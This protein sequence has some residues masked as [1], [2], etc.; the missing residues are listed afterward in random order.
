MMAKRKVLTALT[1]LV[2]LV[3]VLAS[4]GSQ[5]TGGNRKLELTVWN[6]Q[7][8]DYVWKE[9]DEFIPGDWLAEKTGVSVQNIYGNDGG[10]WDSKLT[11]L[12]AGNNLPNII[13][14]QSA[15]GP[16]H[17][18][19]LKELGKLATLTDELI[20]EYAP[21]IWK[22]TPSYIWEQFRAE[23][24]TI[25]GIPFGFSTDD[26]KTVFYDYTDEEIQNLVEL[27]VVP[28]S[29]IVTTISIRDDILKMIYPE[30]KSYDELMALLDEKKEPIGDEIVDV[31]I[32]SAEEF[33]EFMY[34]ISE[35]NLTADGKKVYAF[36]YAGD[37]SDN[38]E[39]I[40]YL[41]NMMY[42][43]GNHE[44]TA[45]WNDKTET[46]EIPLMQDYAKN[47]AQVQ[48]KMI[49]DKV[50]D[51]ESLAHTGAQFSAK[52]YQGAYAICSATR[53]APYASLN[54]QLEE[55]GKTFKYRPLYVDVPAPE[56][57]A[58]YKVVHAF[59]ASFGILNNLSEEQVKQ[60]LKWA[61]LQ[62]TDEFMEVLAWGPKE[63]G[64]YTENADGTRT[65]I[66]ENMQKYFVEGD[67]SALDTAKTKG[68]NIEDKRFIIAPF[69]RGSRWTPS[70]YNKANAL[71]PT[72]QSG[73]KFKSDS[74]YVTSVKPAPPCQ[75]YASE[76]GDVKEVVTYW[77]RREEWETAAKK[78]FAAPEGQFE[79]K[80]EEM[81][82]VVN[83]IVDVSAMEKAMTDIALDYWKD[84]KAVH[85]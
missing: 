53:V 80:W 10:Q 25:I 70:V 20:Q 32:R 77:A 84:I 68:L 62:Y 28:T 82:S 21:N 1:A 83:G 67:T 42:G 69:G 51:P 61:D 38:W 5:T 79:A 4:C 6:T 14:C 9:L 60:V 49:L 15:Q 24:G 48:N 18:N 31:P 36:G 16:A 3:S 30:A 34:K 50:I 52:V 39:A 47:I 75:A 26:L 46:V 65:F 81:K 41:G 74:E 7:G 45:H 12:V 11:K 63:A 66:D 54:K 55:S 71:T 58:P 59:S 19:K 76:F 43:G 57:Y 29:R 23:D 13:W 78:A 64:L 37:G 44:Y 56:G 33:Q 2:L 8:T 85:Q 17:F 40:C 35:L 22:R 72:P 27:R 73:F